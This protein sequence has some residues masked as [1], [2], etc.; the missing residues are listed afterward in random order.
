[1]SDVLPPPIW[2]NTTEKL[3]QLIQ[4]LA[5]QPRIAVDTE[6]NSLHAFREKVCLI[7][8]TSPKADYL[9]DP[10][11]L[12][13]LTMLAPIFAD[14]KIEKVFHAAEYDLICLRRDFGFS[15]ANLFDTMHAAR[16]LGYPAVGLDKLLGDKF[17]VVMD[18]RHQKADWGA[19]PLTK[20]QVHYARFDTHY[21]FALRD[22]LEKELREKERLDL[23][24]E[25]F[26]RACH[27]EDTKGRS[28]GSSWDRFAGRKDL[29]L[30]ELTVVA[31]LCQWRDKEA[32]RLD[33]PPY[34]VMM[35]SVLIALAKNPPEA[36]VDL[37]AAGL[38]EKQIRIWGNA[39]LS[40]VRHGLGA[41]LVERK[42]FPP[43]DD[44]VLRRLEKLKVW[45]KKVGLT[46]KVES[47]IILP[48]PF[49]SILSET[50]PSNMEELKSLMKYAPTRFDK[51]GG[52]ILKILGV[53]HAN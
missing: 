9:V 37:S 42:Q 39:V 21:L 38:S 35:D 30:R 50:P 14:P 18:K 29:S 3:E 32:E 7:Q 13:D 53:K 12:S 48:K 34:K 6:S 28:N 25:D 33:R 4:D 2:V 45:R 23:A 31:H 24:H 44:A 17:N 22:E 5:S 27:L 1:M 15:F 43:K 20:E 46:L 52:Q 49:L 10:L 16:V 19:R 8:F 11:A 41:P 47:D 51:Y 36:K 40:A 26:E